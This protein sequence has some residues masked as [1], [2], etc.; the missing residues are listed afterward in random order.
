M[1]AARMLV[2]LAGCAVV[3][4]LAVSPAGA[5]DPDA[6]KQIGLTPAAEGTF[7][8]DVQGADIRT[9]VRAISEYSGRNINVAE[10][11]R[12]TVSVRLRNVGWREA[13]RTVLRSS[14][15]DFVEEGGILRVDQMT[16]LQ[17]ETVEREQARARQ[18]ELVPLDTRVIKLNYANAAELAA[19][20]QASL[21]RRGSIQVEK[22]TNALIV[23]DLEDN[24]AKI[25]KM[26]VDLDG[27]TPQIEITA[28]LVD[29]DAEALRD[30]GIEWNVAPQ[31]PEFWSSVDTDGDGIDDGL[32]GGGPVHNDDYSVV[33]AGEGNTGIADPAA[34]F[35]F[36]VFKSWASIEAQLQV[37]EQNRKAD[38]ISNPRITTVDNR[39]A[40]ILVGQ[41]IPLI[42]QDVAGNAVSQLQTIGVQLKVTPHLTQ[43]KRI[44]M[45]LH[46]E[47]SDL[48]TQ[49][50]VQGGVIINTSE[51]D[52]RVMV[53][54]GQTA[55]IGGLIRS[56]TSNI[57]RGIPLLKDFP[58]I[59]FLFR[60]ENT[61]R[62][63]R[64]LIIFVTPRI[65]TSFA[66]NEE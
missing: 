4:G 56:N 61:V 38:I 11:V 49:S 10:G 40:K 55:V 59:G 5:A 51:A 62:Q 22:R 6:M 19:A 45:D 1:R 15:L 23:N 58:L 17:T 43:D 41:K 28:K 31:E 12:G 13:L 52:T 32:P 33:G 48:S 42:I 36:G 60:S 46:P 9:V 3:L 50:T 34:A 39:E 64:E 24:V 44:V 35:T 21:S 20:L 7:S 25:E 27:T 29:V 57:R 65:V 30:I 8:L 2:V 47:V 16:K 53:D 37:L 14:G 18:A 63:N 66:T 26:A 54:D